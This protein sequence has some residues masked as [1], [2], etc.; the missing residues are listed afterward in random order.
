VCRSPR[1]WLGTTVAT[2]GSVAVGA[3]GRGRGRNREGLGWAD[4]PPASRQDATAA[5]GNEMPSRH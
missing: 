4:P 1:G 2:V 3:D 5:R